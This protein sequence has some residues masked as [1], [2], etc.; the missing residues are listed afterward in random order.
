MKRFVCV[1][2]S[3]FA[4]VAQANN[5]V[6]AVTTA[7]G[8]VKESEPKKQ[9]P[10]EELAFEDILKLNEEL[11]AELAT[12]ESQD[13]KKLAYDRYYNRRY[14]RYYQSYPNYH[15]N[16][17]YY[18]PYYQSYPSYYYPT[19]PYYGGHYYYGSPGFSIG[20]NL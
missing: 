7:P 5:P 10:Q 17:R 8:S 2:A 11:K 12:L 4:F 20:I 16:Y 9:L 3:L 1:F 15:Y 14:P 6:S 13:E 18:Q 19:Q